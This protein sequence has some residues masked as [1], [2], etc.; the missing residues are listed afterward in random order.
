MQAMDQVKLFTSLLYSTKLS[1]NIAAKDNSLLLYVLLTI[2]LQDLLLHI[3]KMGSLETI[4]KTPSSFTFVTI[5]RKLM[6]V[7]F[8]LMKT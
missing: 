5:C 2:G 1:L 8:I 4:S 3:A 7:E 6:K